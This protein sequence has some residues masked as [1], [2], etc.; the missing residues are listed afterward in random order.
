LIGSPP[1]IFTVYKILENEKVSESFY[2][3]CENAHIISAR[4]PMT[5]LYINRLEQHL[6]SPLYTSLVQTPER[7]KILSH[8][9]GI[10]ELLPICFL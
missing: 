9:S 3:V 7:Y 10:L 8:K 4:T 2:P 5:C 1:K 6:L